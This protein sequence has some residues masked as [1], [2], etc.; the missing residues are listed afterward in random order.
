MVPTYLEFI[1]GRPRWR[2][3][4]EGQK[5][6]RQWKE[7]NGSVMSSAQ[8]FGSTDAYLGRE[9]TVFGRLRRAAID[10][11]AS[12]AAPTPSFT[13]RPLFFIDHQRPTMT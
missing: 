7:A 1:T 8:R 3:N 2:K 5:M 13:L 11:G 10:I 9:D 12:A 6:C 4:I